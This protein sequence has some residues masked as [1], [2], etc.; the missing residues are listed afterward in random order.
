VS[1]PNAQGDC[2]MIWFVH[3]ASGQWVAFFG[4]IWDSRLSQYLCFA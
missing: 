1:F 4:A 2:D 3:F